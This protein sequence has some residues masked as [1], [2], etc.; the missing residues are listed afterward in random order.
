MPVQPP[1]EGIY[2]FS[3]SSLFW[4]LHLAVNF[5]T[6]KNQHM[7]SQELI[8]TRIEDPGTLEKFSKIFG[9]VHKVEDSEA[10][11][12]FEVEKFHFM[13]EVQEKGISDVTPISAMGVFLDVVSNGLSFASGAKHI[14]LMSRNVKIKS[15]NQESWEKRLVFTP[16]PDG[17]IF[18]AQKAGAI[19]YVTKP[20]IVYEGDQF[21][22]STDSN[23]DQIIR[24]QV[25]FPRSSK[26]IIGGYVYVVMKNGKRE[27]FWMD[28]GD[29]ERLKGYSAKQNKGTA[30]A[31]YTSNDGQIDSGFF[32]AKLINF[33]L[34]NVRK[35]GIASAFEVNGDLG[36]AAIITN[37]TE[38]IEEE[39]PFSNQS[40][41][42]RNSS[43]ATTTQSNASKEPF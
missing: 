19:D 27:P 37:T 8:K 6:F 40:N 23:G 32:G 22:I 29:I 4:F 33:A 34:K 31:L 9:A 21:A 14:Y 30:N 43:P 1:D 7:S 3:H 2:T 11:Q 26:K 39:S 18:Q 5:L 20:V 12:M 35:S 25:Q 28:I 10:K 13:K 15:G 42:N 17:K 41:S 24:H 38:I 36:D 16:T